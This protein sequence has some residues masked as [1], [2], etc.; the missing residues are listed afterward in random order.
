MLYQQVKRRVS[1][2]DV[3]AGVL[4]SLA[5]LSAALLALEFDRVSRVYPLTVAVLLCATGI[6]I[7]VN[8]VLRSDAGVSV[9]RHLSRIFL[10][11]VVTALWAAA[12]LGGGGF[13]IPTL[14]MQMSL[15]ALSGL[16]RPIYIALIAAL[17]TTI[18]YAF[19]VVLLDV[20]LP[21]ALWFGAL[22]GA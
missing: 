14:L 9:D 8:Q 17:V 2:P 5:G 1:N 12:L 16:R 10:A 6:G 13:V 7:V 18:A 20:P 4:L 11:A 21:P 22:A 19:F 3:I 15:L